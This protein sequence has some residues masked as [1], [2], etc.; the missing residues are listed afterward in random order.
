MH[1]VIGS[2]LLSALFLMTL[3]AIAATAM[4]TRLQLDIYRNRLLI[5]SDE[6]YLASQ[7]VGFWAMGSLVDPKT[8]LTLLGEGGR[9][10]D[11]PRAL[12]SIYPNVTIK[13]HLYDLQAR[14]NLNNLQNKAQHPLFF[15]LLKN[16]LKNNDAKLVKQISDATVH[17]IN[18]YR[19]DQ[20]QDEWT[21]EYAKQNPPYLPG[22][23]PMQS[24]SEFRLV[25]GVSARIDEL[26]SPLLT[27]LPLQTP[28]NINTAPMPILKILGNGL[29]DA[30]LTE[31]LELRLD[32]GAFSAT[33]LPL[34]IGKLNIPLDQIS[35]GSDYFL[36]V[37]TVTSANLSLQHYTIIHREMDQKGEISAHIVSETLNAL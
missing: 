20:G 18:P 10:L 9:V 16:N 19:M 14:F 32:K 21:T 22:F 1:K 8:E 12:K 24:V 31:L 17:W 37:T 36:S 25:A 23:Q 27:A 28:I 26:I 33:D 3:V 13:G 34:L 4:S 2:A 29:T 15:R 7:V 11:Y 6:V 30:E 35:I 5:E